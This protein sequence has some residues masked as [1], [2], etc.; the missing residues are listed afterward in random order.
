MNN[1]NAKSYGNY[2]NRNT[3]YLTGSSHHKHLKCPYLNNN[4]NYTG[5]SYSNGF[6]TFNK[7]N[8]PYSNNLYMNNSS[9]S[10]YIN[11]NANTN[12]IN[13]GNQSNNERSR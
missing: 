8:N 5:I 6:N 9:Q 13:I 4:M 3:I 12:N 10:F 7:Y 2:I 11:N 1:N